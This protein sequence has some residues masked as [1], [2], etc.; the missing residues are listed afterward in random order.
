MS[1]VEQLNEQREGLMGL[2]ERGEAARRLAANPD[3]K[4]L[5]LEGFCR[6]DAAAYVQL[7]QDPALPKENREDALNIAQ[8]SGHLKRFMSVT[9]QKAQQAK[10]TID[11]V[12][13]AL[14]EAR[15]EGGE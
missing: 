8:A 2:I 4:K 9:I 11:A 7:S 12:D 10:Q 15:Q 1:E 13:Q 6:D 5:V 14:V 3:F